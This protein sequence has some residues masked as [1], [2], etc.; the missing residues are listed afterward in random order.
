[1]LTLCGSTVPCWYSSDLPIEPTSPMW[2]VANRSMTVHR[3][4]R[5]PQSGGAGLSQLSTLG[6][7]WPRTGRCCSPGRSAWRSQLPSPPAHCHL[8]NS[9]STATL[10]S[11]AACDRDE[12]SR[13]AL[14]DRPFVLQPVLGHLT[15]GRSEH[16]PRRRSAPRGSCV[17]GQRSATGQ[18]DDDDLVPS[19]RGGGKIVTGRRSA[20][21]MHRDQVVVVDATN[22]SPQP[23]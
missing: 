6:M 18:G 7:T 19:S 14:H 11:K 5:E 23:D 3:S 22:P 2:C 21:G 16:L 1:M 9:P 12:G 13:P 10:T 15:N 17:T 8:F 4:G 20:S